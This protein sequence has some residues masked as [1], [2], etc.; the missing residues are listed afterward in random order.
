MT[1]LSPAPRAWLPLLALAAAFAPGCRLPPPVDHGD[2]YPE[3]DQA[4]ADGAADLIAVRVILIACR[5][6]WP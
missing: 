2:L 1:R 4:A 5:G 6:H 3:R